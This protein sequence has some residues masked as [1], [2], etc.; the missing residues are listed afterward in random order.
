M[1]KKEQIR[2]IFWITVSFILTHGFIFLLTGT[3]WDEKTWAFA[4]TEK[5][6]D[7]SLQL[8]RPS[9]FFLMKF[10]FEIPEELAR[11]IIVLCFYLGTLGVYYI[12]SQIPGIKQ[13]HALMMTLLYIA[14]PANDARAMRGIF[15]Y[16]FGYCFFIM[17]FCMLIVLKKKYQFRYYLLRIITLLFFICSFT[18][19]STL[20]FYAI[21]LMYILCY[22]LKNRRLSECYKFFDFF[23]VPFAFYIVKNK[24]FPAYGLYAGYNNVSLAGMCKSIFQTFKIC[25]ARLKD[26]I[27]YWAC[28]KITWILIIVCFFLIYYILNR[29]GKQFFK[30]MASEKVPVS[31]RFKMFF[32]GCITMWLG[33]YAYVVVGQDCSLTG[34]TGRSSVLLGF[35]AAMIFFAVILWVPGDKMKMLLCLIATLGGILHFTS[36]YLSYQEDYYRQQDLMFELRQN[37]EALRDTK[38]ILYLTHTEPV[39]HA[40][41]F[42]TLNSNGAEAFGDQSH[43]IM[44]GYEDARYLQVDTPIAFEHLVYDGDYQMAD[45]EIGRSSEIEA[46]IV[47]E[48]DSS[49]WEI[50]S[51]KA[52]ELID[53]HLFEEKLFEDSNL[54]V[55][56]QEM[57]EFENMVKQARV[58]S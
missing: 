39:I 27:T 56:T 30:H 22:L 1:E 21:P 17:A 9:I 35:G 24:L 47:Y 41:R 20:V 13:R 53:R 14:I 3:W 19:N 18:L 37:T 25:F 49:V 23:A 28:G 48:N 38:N 42:Y 33:A 8:G 40:T 4:E 31:L 10:I 51:L 46:I 45:Y 7:I 6:W 26:M 58:S 12:Y 2:N 5:M 15:P 44:N 43:F 32:G 57:K 55:Y 34:V 50:L 16:T 29:K 52:F 11:T 54:I 36:Y